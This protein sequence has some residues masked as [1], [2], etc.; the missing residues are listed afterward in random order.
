M[1]ANFMEQMMQAGKLVFDS[2]VPF[3]LKLMLP[4]A[5]A[6][7][8]LWPLDLMPGLPFD[9]I[10]VLFVALSFFVQLANQAI[11]KQTAQQAAGGQGANTGSTGPTSNDGVVDTTWR[12]IE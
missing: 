2:R 3:S 10:A 8:W 7:Y 1:P 4:I 6:L 9:D 11:G 5:A 12:V